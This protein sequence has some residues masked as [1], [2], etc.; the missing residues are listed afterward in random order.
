VL[1]SARKLVH[2][3]SGDDFGPGTAMMTTLAA[4]LAV[5]SVLIVV[6][7]ALSL[8]KVPVVLTAAQPHTQKPNRQR[9]IASLARIVPA[10]QRQR[11]E[12]GSLADLPA[13][14][15]AVL[16]LCGPDGARLVVAHTSDGPLQSHSVTFEKHTFRASL[17]AVVALESAEPLLKLINQGLAASK[18]PRSVGL[19]FD[20]QT[21]WFAVLEPGFAAR[22]RRV[23]VLVV[24]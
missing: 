3:P 16:A 10:A 8:R 13:L 18:S 2:E 11:F 23:G 4:V 21:H 14:M 22:L 24:P 15:Q 12:P 17:P 1:V 9:V 5:V 7:V 19:L 20:Q 6:L